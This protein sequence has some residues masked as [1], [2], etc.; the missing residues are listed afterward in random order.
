GDRLSG[1]RRALRGFDLR[2]G[3]TFA[4]LNPL[5]HFPVIAG[6]FPAPGLGGLLAAATRFV[7]GMTFG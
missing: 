5:A 4:R 3:E 2:Y 6:E 1:P 7:L